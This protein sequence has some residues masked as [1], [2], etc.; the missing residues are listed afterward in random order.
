MRVFLVK[1]VNRSIYKSYENS[2]MLIYCIKL[3][4]ALYLI[5]YN[6]QCGQW[7]SLALCVR[8]EVNIMRVNCS[9]QLVC[10]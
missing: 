5:N 4:R 6:N 7:C 1:V 10:S 9:K 2:S 3:D 8:L